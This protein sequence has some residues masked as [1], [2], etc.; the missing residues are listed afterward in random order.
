MAE[1]Q[2]LAVRKVTVKELGRPL[3][4]RPAS[5]PLARNGKSPP[6]AADGMTR[7][8]FRKFWSSW[9]KLGTA[10]IFAQV[11]IKFDQNFDQIDHLVWEQSAKLTI[12]KI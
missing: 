5:T 7:S 3:S 8:T 11:L 2:L 12:C 4:R 6:K 1:N 9:L 10:L